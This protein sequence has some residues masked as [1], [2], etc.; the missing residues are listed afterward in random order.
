MGCGCRDEDEDRVWV[1]GKCH[2]GFPEDPKGWKEHSLICTV[3][4][5]KDRVLRAIEMAYR[6][7]SLADESIGWDE[8]GDIL[9]DELCNAYGADVYSNWVKQF[10]EGE[11]SLAK[12]AK[13][14]KECA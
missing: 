12:F 6:K 2:K 1:C 14:V 7:H 3:V 4:T 13:K 9:C 10:D 11:K 8:L 5:P